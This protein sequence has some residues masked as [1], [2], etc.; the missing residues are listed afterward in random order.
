M[1][2]CA[3]IDGCVFTCFS[4]RVHYPVFMHV[5]YV[6]TNLRV[7]FASACVF[8]LPRKPVISTFLIPN[9]LSVCEWGGL[10][11]QIAAESHHISVI[12]VYDTDGGG[13]GLQHIRERKTNRS[14]R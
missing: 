7:H 11:L 5:C 9:Q 14:P 13:G 3:D 1:F 8:P 2:L 4:S 12:H 10:N 6:A